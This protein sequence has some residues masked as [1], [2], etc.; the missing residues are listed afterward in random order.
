MYCLQSCMCGFGAY[1]GLS[2]GVQPKS[3]LYTHWLYPL[4]V[5][6]IIELWCEQLVIRKQN[7][8]QRGLAHKD[9]SPMGADS[10]SPSKSFGCEIAGKQGCTISVSITKREILLYFLPTEKLGLPHS[11]SLTVFSF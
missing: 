10:T 2:M 7:L 8:R 11:F 6:V 9:W 3:Q 4:S 5:R 1:I